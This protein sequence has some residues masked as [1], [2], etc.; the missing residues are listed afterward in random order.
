MSCE[1]ELR[2]VGPFHVR[3]RSFFVVTPQLSAVFFLYGEA[4]ADCSVLPK[5]LT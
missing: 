1:R 4:V 5:V 3:K 2:N